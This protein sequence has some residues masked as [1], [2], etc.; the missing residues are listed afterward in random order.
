MMT[1]ASS[2]SDATN[3][4][5]LIDNTIVVIHDHNMFIIHATEL[6]YINCHFLPKV[7]FTIIDFQ[8]QKY[9]SVCRV[10]YDHTYDHNLCS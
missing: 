10:P 1:L 3:V 2:V 5:S 7:D 9:T 4:A 8:S 6:E